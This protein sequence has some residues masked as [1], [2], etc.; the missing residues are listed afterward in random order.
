MFGIVAEFHCDLN[1]ADKGQLQDLQW[2]DVT[3][4]ACGGRKSA[5]CITSVSSDATQYSCTGKL[6][7]M[8]GNTCF[9]NSVGS[10]CDLNMCLLCFANASVLMADDA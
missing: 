9:L 5:R 10:S 7:H 8:F 1:H 2:N 4:G 6:Q 3:C